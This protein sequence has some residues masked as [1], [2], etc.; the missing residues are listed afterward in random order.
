MTF[1]YLLDEFKQSI[2]LQI[3]DGLPHLDQQFL[4]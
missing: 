4:W 1:F 3:D 2:L